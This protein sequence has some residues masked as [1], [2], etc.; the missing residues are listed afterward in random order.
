M[1]DPDAYKSAHPDWDKKA[2]KNSLA[3]RVSNGEVSV[4]GLHIYQTV[5]NAE[6]QLSVYNDLHY[7]IF[8]QH[9]AKIAYQKVDGGHDWLSWRSS[10]INGLVALLPSQV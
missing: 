3:D 9:G 8:K 7:D 2:G 1:Q 6:T 10:L 5:G 4:V